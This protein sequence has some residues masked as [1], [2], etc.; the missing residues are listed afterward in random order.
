MGQDQLS[1]QME[2]YE[3]WK[4]DLIETIQAFQDWLDDHEMGAPEHDLQIYETMESLRKDR[5]NIAFVGEFSRGKTE[6]INAIFFSE[7][8]TRLLPAEAGRTTM[9]PTELFYDNEVAQP[10]IRLLPIRTRKDDRSISAFKNDPSLWSMTMLDVNSPTQLAEAMLE[11]VRTEVVS[12]RE[13]NELG[14]Y[15]KNS[16]PHY[17]ETGQLPKNVEIPMW[18][19]ALVS[20]PH[21]LLKQ[22]LVILDTPGLNALGNEPELT[23]SMLPSS[24]GL[25]FMLATDTGV[26]GSDMDIWRHHVNSIR[27]KG[28]KGLVVVL[29]KIDTLWDDL[30]SPEAVN[31]NIESQRR[32]TASQLRIE[33]EQIFPI[34]AQKAL[35]AKVRNDSDLLEKS[36]LNTVEECLSSSILPN[37][38]EIARDSVLAQIGPIQDQTRQILTGRLEQITSQLRELH[39]LHGK[40]DDVIQ[41][42]MHQ[43]NEEQAIYLRNVKSFQASR[44][45]LQSQAR[46]M[47]HALSMD[48]LDRLITKTRKDMTN[49]W[50]TTGLKRGMKVFFEGARAA[51]VEVNTQA[52]QTRMLIR[53]TYQKFHREHG[54][55]ALVPKTFTV[56]EYNQDLERLYHDAEVFRN[57]PITVMTEQSFVTKKFFISLV[58]QTRNIFFKA[59]QNAN[60]WLKQVMNP[61]VKQIQEHKQTMDKRL[62]TLKKI[63]ESRDNLDSRIKDLEKQQYDLNVQITELDKVREK[64]YRPLPSLSNSTA[65]TVDEKV[66]A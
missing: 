22:G 15:D 57:S 50:T 42:L 12:L 48:Y 61:L 14:L 64:I 29:N 21:P 40:N 6:L 28:S 36:R 31:A 27:A 37:K 34:S 30:K 26:T 32:E 24:Q 58:S 53:A 25:F 46:A 17:N 45:V 59:N 5:L 13:A 8:G 3:A 35:L 1:L 49:S 9:C 55:P 41:K 63:N 52:E 39:S 19:H 18:R 66:T 16:D 56:D 7:H 60:A 23:L 38:Q 54:L 51:M 4:A 65:Q 47:L 11:V 10:Y 44:T 62:T 43:S 2:S 20:Y 33:P